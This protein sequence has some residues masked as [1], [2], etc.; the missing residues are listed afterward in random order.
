M[1]NGVEKLLTV[2]SGALGTP[3]GLAVNVNVPCTRTE[4]TSFH[5]PSPKKVV[6]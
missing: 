6:D 1:V 4:G 2:P 5:S 3:D